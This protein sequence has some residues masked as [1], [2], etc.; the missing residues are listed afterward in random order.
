[1]KNFLLISLS[2]PSE[3][4][5]QSTTKFNQTR[6]KLMRKNVATLFL[7]WPP[8]STN[9]FFCLL[10]SFLLSKIDFKGKKASLCVSR[11]N[12]MSHWFEPLFFLLQG[13]IKKC[14]GEQFFS[15]P[16]ISNFLLKLQQRYHLRSVI[17]WTRILKIFI[18]ESLCFLYWLFS[19]WNRNNAND[20]N[21]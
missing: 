13:E 18:K 2:K 4:Q 17:L 10:T 1:M 9:N 19:E 15:V 5:V 8:L 16:N 3:S 12:A 21:A 20:K 7:K 6:R 11:K 14:F